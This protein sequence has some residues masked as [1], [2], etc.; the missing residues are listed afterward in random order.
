M[1]AIVEMIAGMARSYNLNNID[2]SLLIAETI[3]NPCFYIL[4]P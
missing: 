4:C 2:A 3:I 1:P